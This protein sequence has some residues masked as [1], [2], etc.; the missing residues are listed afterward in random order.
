MPLR[1]GPFIGGFLRVSCLP[2]RV[3]AWVNKMWKGF[4]VTM[5]NQSKLWPTIWYWDA[6]GCTACLRAARLQGNKI[7][8]DYWE[9]IIPSASVFVLLYQ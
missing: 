2:M 8:W 6:P 7:V 1:K 5:A 9:G 4:C 3:G